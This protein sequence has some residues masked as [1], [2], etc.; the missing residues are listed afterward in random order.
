MKYFKVL[1]HILLVMCIFTV[2][3]SATSEV[4]SISIVKNTLELDSAVFMNFKVKSTN[5]ENPDDIKLLVWENYPGEFTISTADAILTSMNTEDGTGYHVFQYNNLAAKDMTK[6]VY[7][8]A[9][10]EVDGTEI[11]SNTAK[12][13]IA[14]Y[15]Y[16]VI[17]NASSDEELKTLIGDMLT[18]GAS[19]QRYF[20]HKTDFLATDEVVKIKVVNGKHFDGFSTGYYKAGTEI[21]ITANEPDDG[22]IFECWKDAEGTVLS[23]DN[24]FVISECENNIYTAEYSEVGSTGGDSSDNESPDENTEGLAYRYREKEYTSSKTELPEPWV[25]ESIKTEYTHDNYQTIRIR[26]S[27]SGSE[28]SSGYTSSQAD[29]WKLSNASKYCFHTGKSLVSEYMRKT[30]YNTGAEYIY[31]SD[32]Q[33]IDYTKYTNTGNKYWEFECCTTKTPYDVY[34]YYKWGEW[35][36]WSATP[37]EEN[38][39]IE[40]EIQKATI[41][42]RYRDKQYTTSKSSLSEPWVL[43]NTTTEYT[44]TGT[45]KVYLSSS[46]TIDSSYCVHS[47]ES[48]RK[49]TAPSGGSWFYATSSEYIDMLVNNSSLSS[50]TSQTGFYCYTC[51]TSKTSYKLYHY[52]KIGEWSDWSETPAI[53]TENREVETKLDIHEHDYSV[54]VT[55]PSCTTEGYSTYTCSSCGNGYVSDYTDALGHSYIDEIVEPTCTEQGYTKHICK[56]CGNNYIDEY[57][58]SLGHNYENNVCTCCG[59]QSKSVID[60]GT[61]GENLTWTLYEEGLLTIE[62]KGKMYDYFEVNTPLRSLSPWYQYKDII[63]QVVFDNDVTSV[64]SYAF[65]LHKNIETVNIGNFVKTI[66]EKAFYSCENIKNIVLPDSVVIVYD[67]AFFGCI[68]LVNLHLGSSLE[69]IGESSFRG[70]T[71]LESLSFPDSLERIREYAFSGCTSLTSVN[72]SS[73]ITY[74]G[75]G[76][77]HNCTS[78]INVYTDIEKWCGIEFSNPTA[79]PLLYAKNF[80]LDNELITTELVIPNNVSSIGKNAFNGYDEITKVII[81]NSVTSIGETAFENCNNL[82]SVTI[83]GEIDIIGE[84]AFSSCENLSSVVLSDGIKTIVDWMFAGCDSLVSI[85]IPN[86]VTS[87]GRQAFSNCSNLTSIIIPDSVTSIGSQAFSNC[88]NLTSITIPGSVTSIGDDA[89]YY[90]NNLTTM[91]GVSGSIAEIWANNMKIDFIAIDSD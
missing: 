34:C 12:F 7:A 85:T 60:L 62:G 5:I 38:D 72:I 24:V 4:P 81:P 47:K 53:A 69:Y 37:I 67:W 35:S 18:Y 55:P 58:D 86:S 10:V 42:Y 44:H 23:T 43:Y 8:R 76:A 29:D 30:G 88:S 91:Y 84:A 82:V 41:L 65:W 64:G 68:N 80:Y 14:Q 19:A 74:I 46:E 83:Q 2:T 3:V 17:N 20:N 70:C 79:N 56:V 51:C 39:N 16:N 11:Y 66:G 73:Y 57:I 49:Y 22:Y 9:Y 45:Q 90:C 89:F 59:E 13:S 33:S 78:I 54:V 48:V 6:F 63:K 28:T 1:I 15:A 32:P 77:F 36:D 40:V 50:Y 61:C 31:T 52:Q 71:N 87:V 75:S 25:F 21:T 27:V 26:A